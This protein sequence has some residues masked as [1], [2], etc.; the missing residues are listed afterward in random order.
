MTKN[1]SLDEYQ[2]INEGVY[3]LAK[4]SCHVLEVLFSKPRTSKYFR[5]ACVSEQLC[6]LGTLVSKHMRQRPPVHERPAL[7][8]VR[9]W[10]RRRMQ[11]CFSLHRCSNSSLPACFTLACQTR[12]AG[13]IPM[14]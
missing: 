14:P 8:H 4:N 6:T 1:T 2:I 9:F 13:L 7:W 10:G 11:W 3:A 12:E 5:S